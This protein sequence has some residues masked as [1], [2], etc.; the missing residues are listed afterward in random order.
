MGPESGFGLEASVFYIMRFRQL[1]GWFAGTWPEP[2]VSKIG[3]PEPIMS[4]IFPKN[5]WFNNDEKL[6][7]SFF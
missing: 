7:C 3:L 5:T 1:F 4:E 2:T 6:Y